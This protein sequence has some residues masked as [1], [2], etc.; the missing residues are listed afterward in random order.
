ME[1]SFCGEQTDERKPCNRAFDYRLCCWI[2]FL[3][4]KQIIKGIIMAK[5]SFSILPG[6][7]LNVGKNGFTSFTVGKRGR[8]VNF[9]LDNQ[10]ISTEEKKYKSRAGRADASK[11]VTGVLCR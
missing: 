3:G 11:F 9:K 10:P 4:V 2:G 6:I 1:K 7:K 8:N 5:S